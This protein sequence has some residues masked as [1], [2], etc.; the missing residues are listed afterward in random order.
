MEDKIEVGEY[1]RTKKGFIDKVLEI[2][3]EYTR[4]NGNY[5]I[6]FRL[7]DKKNYWFSTKDIVKHSKNIID[8]I[9]E[10]DYVNGYEV[11]TVYSYDENGNDKDELGICEV[12]DDYAYYTYLEDIDI[13]SI[14]TKEQFDSVKYITDT[15]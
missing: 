15:K 13:K 9:E 14:V 10:G 5:D 12:D 11:I 7:S 1:V 4:M 3:T 6:V 8:L 2:K